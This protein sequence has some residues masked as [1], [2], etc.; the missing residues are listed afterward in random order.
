MFSTGC[1]G[2]PS[3]ARAAAEAEL[4]AWRVAIAVLFAPRPAPAFAHP[5][6]HAE[7]EDAIGPLARPRRGFRGRGER[8]RVLD[9][10]RLG[11]D[12]D[13]QRAAFDELR[14]GA[15]QIAD[16]DAQHPLRR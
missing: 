3:A 15:Q 2:V 16:D 11:G 5:P 1:G 4:E 8:L 9:A 12:V 13:A 7:A 10:Q 14:G 6:D